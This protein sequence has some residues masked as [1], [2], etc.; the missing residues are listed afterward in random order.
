MNRIDIHDYPRRLAEALTRLD[1]SDS[2]FENKRIIREFARAL[3]VKGISAPRVEKY[4]GTLRLIGLAL[5]KDL[6]VA[7]K[8]DL[9]DF[10][11]KIR[12]R[13]DRS[14]WTK[15]DYAITLHRFYRWLDGKDVKM[16]D[17]VSGISTTIKKREQPRI[18]KAELLSEEDIKALLQAADNPRD[19]ALIATTWDTGGRIGEVGGLSVSDLTFDEEGTLIDLRGKT[20]ARNVLAIECTA[21]LLNWLQ[22]HPRKDEPG[23]PLWIGLGNRPRQR[24]HALPYNA[25][26]ALFKRVFKA[27]GLRK[28]FN[29]HL[30]RHSRAT[31]CV[32]H[33]WSTYE[34]CRH[35]GWELDSG[36]PAVYL[37]LSDGM[38]H[39]KMRESYGYSSPE[40]RNTNV[41]KKCDRCSHSNPSG[42]FRCARCGF[43]LSA[44]PNYKGS[45]QRSSSEAQLERVLRDPRVAEL[46]TRVLSEKVAASFGPQSERASVHP[47]SDLPPL[48]PIPETARAIQGDVLDPPSDQGRLGFESSRIL[49]GPVRAMKDREE[50][51][52]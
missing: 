6:G 50:E 36:M 1:R 16:S 4:V 11:L 26:Y 15:T 40:I 10:M 31:W 48:P 14:I 30:F 28:R 27:A 5:S 12:A 2:S 24:G 19:K 41:P 44:R 29:P 22:N 35:F 34:L 18:K 25:I 21:Y 9:E 45:E 17:R 23:A 43:P 49:H 39:N 33:G 8:A 47:G 51:L 38:V 32:E 13:Q 46:I 20:G 37:S 3:Q 52:V 42:F 7:T